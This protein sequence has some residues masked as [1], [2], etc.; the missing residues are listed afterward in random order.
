MKKFS[1]LLIKGFQVYLN[2]IYLI[3]NE[4]TKVAGLSVFAA[5]FLTKG[6]IKTGVN[7]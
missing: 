6:K 3:E 7:E 2:I 1:I 5:K 4:K